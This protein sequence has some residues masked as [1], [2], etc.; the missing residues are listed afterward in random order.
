MEQQQGSTLSRL[1]RHCLDAAVKGPVAAKSYVGR[2]ATSGEA[3]SHLLRQ[4]QSVCGQYHTRHTRVGLVVF[5][6]WR[7]VFYLR[8]RYGWDGRTVLCSLEPIPA[9]E[10]IELTP[11]PKVGVFPH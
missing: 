7:P 4:L 11:F 2:G 6:D 1:C 8:Y 5:L 3:Y 9:A 10:V